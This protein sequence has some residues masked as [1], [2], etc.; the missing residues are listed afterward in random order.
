MDRRNFL[1]KSA[2]AGVGISALTNNIISAP[3]IFTES[4][5]R[6]N[7]EKGKILFKPYIVQNG[8]GP[9]LG[10]I[11]SFK[12]IGPEDWD[13][14]SWAFASD[15]EWDAFYSNIFVDD[16]GV[17]ISDAA[18]KDKFGIN[19]R[20]NVE[21]FG[22][23]YM[24]ADNGGEYYSLPQGGKELKYNLNYELA[25]SRIVANN[26][27]VKKFANSGYTPNSEVKAFLDL[28]DE[29]LDNASR[30]NIDEF[31]KA[32]N[33]QKGLYYAM[34]A[35][36][37]LELDKAWFDIA[38]TKYREDFFLG[39]DTEDWK[40]MDHNLFM[41]LFSETFNYA[42]ITYYLNGFQ[43]TEGQYNWNRTDEKFKE[44]RKRGIKVEGRPL[45]WAD[46]CCCP[47]WLTSK[48]YPEIL[49]YAEKF[50]KD[51]VSHY[52]DEMY[53]WEIINEAHDF[54][55]ILKLKPD[56]MVEVAKLIAETAKSVN[57]KVHRL[58]NNCCI[59]ADYIQI[60]DWDR[61]DSKFPLV[62]PHQFIKMC[63]EAGVDFT[64]TG[65][66]L[67]YQYSN[68]DL[69]DIIR[70]MERLEKFGKPVQ[71]TEIGT[72]SG[73]NCHNKK[74]GW[75]DTSMPDVPYTW[76][77]HWDEDLQAEWMEKIYTLHYSKPWVEAINWYDQ[78]DGYSFIKNGGILSS[79]DGTKKEVYNKFTELRKKWKEAAKG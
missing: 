16:N 57:P 8:K 44:L 24:T 12:N 45:F 60:I 77:R 52:G 62:T 67:Y 10:R 7:T 18:G 31:K 17:S 3:T 56:Q 30:A 39:C 26:N 47:K 61:F 46:E 38:R 73:C 72:T 71:V 58:I 15:T 29:F 5:T 20:W 9:H 21:G 34:H 78:V 65:Q 6:I 11:K 23:I 74:D 59:Q 55:N 79:T 50:T 28:S 37:M 53:A 75:E 1:I 41:D 68:R 27:R 63:Y 76:H 49:K 69:A 54:D 51:M 2:I 48:S 19:V 25:K 42:T 4:R 22:Y 14:P 35:G 32:Q 13:F 33:A 64:L 66:Q 36:E 43:P 40:E 70:M